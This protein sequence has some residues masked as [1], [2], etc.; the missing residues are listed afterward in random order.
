[1]SQPARTAALGLLTGLLGGC[2]VLLPDPEPEVVSPEWGYNGEET[3]VVIEGSGFWPQIEADAGSSGIG[4]VD[5]GFAVYLDDGSQHALSGVTL[6]DYGTLT[7]VVPEGLDAGVYDLVVEGP[8]GALGTLID[9]F[10]VT[11]TRADALTIDAEDLVYEVY[12]TAWLAVQLVDPEGQPLLEDLDVVVTVQTSNGENGAFEADSLLD[13]QAVDSTEG[14][15]IAG[16]LGDDGF[17]QIGVTMYEP[18][19]VDIVVEAFE[20]ESQVAEGV[21]PAQWEAGSSLTLSIALPDED[22]TAEAGETFEVVLT[23][24]DQYDNVVDDVTQ[25]VVLSNRCG[26][27]DASL[28][29][30][31]TE[32]LDVELTTATSDSCEADQLYAVDGPEGES[33]EFA[34]EAAVADTFSVTVDEGPSIAGEVDLDVFITPRDRFGNAADYTTTV[35]TLMDSVGGLDTTAGVGSATCVGSEL[36]YCAASGV[37]AAEDIVLTVSDPDGVSGTSNTY[38]IIAGDP[39]EVS[40]EVDS[41]PVTAGE[42]FVVTV[43]VLDAWGNVIDLD[44]LGAGSIALDDELSE[45]DCATGELDEDGGATFACTLYTAVSTNAFTASVASLSLEGTSD[46]FEVVNG[47]LA[48]AVI[49]VSDTTVTAGT[50]FEAKVYGYDAWGNLYLVQSDP[51]IDLEDTTGTWSVTSATL[52]A[53]ASATSLGTITVAGQTEL[54]ASQYGVELGSS[55]VITVE[56]GTISSLE[57]LVDEAWV[58]AG[59]AA[60]TYVT[61]VDAYGNTATSYAGDVE[62]NSVNGS[63][64]SITVALTAGEGAKAFVWDD[65]ALPDQLEGSTSGGKTG[66]SDDIYVVANCSTGPTARLTFSGYEEGVA[67]IAVSTGLATVSASLATSTAG[68]AALGWYGL[69]LSQTFDV[70][71]SDSFSVKIR[72]AGIYPA[73]ALVVDT[74]GCADEVDGWVYIGDDDGEPVGPLTVDLG[75]TGL[76]AG[77]STSTTS[78]TVS[79]VRDCTRDVSTGTVVL[80]TDLGDVTGA[81]S[82]GAGLELA[83]DSTGAASATLDLTTTIHDGTSNVWVGAA[84]GAALGQA[85]LLVDDESAHPFV[86]SQVPSGDTS[87][88]VSSIV[89]VLSEPL[90]SASV[91]TTAFTIETPDGTLLEPE[92]VAISSDAQTL[93][94]TLEDPVDADDGLFSVEATTSLRDRSGNRLD[95]TWSGASSTYTGWFGAVSVGAD[96]VDACEAD[97]STFRPDGDDGSGI[98]G[99]EVQ[100]TLESDTAPERWVVTVFDSDGDWVRH[101]RPSAAGATDTWL[102]DG[103]GSDGIIVPNGVY[104]IE[105]DADDGSGNRAGACTVEVT[106]D[107]LLE[108]LDE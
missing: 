2:G 84:S 10:T 42:S 63:G 54:M 101:E 40:V 28:F 105:I 88:S 19:R 8:T 97:V 83:L 39:A 30:Q 46:G 50:S 33:D 74:V 32:T 59:D 90:L 18:S 21:F 85:S 94:L 43:L 13:Q 44:T 76:S 23:V 106:V 62:V 72:E 79:D 102:W 9:G 57:V 56:P 67:C 55:T 51:R 77:V 96:P 47:D 22:F 104:S 29:V 27:F 80:R 75:D 103:R 41:D 16:R 12:D 53:S 81:S 100:L 26:G 36:I 49:V 64:D 14:F 45:A 98:E 86:Y 60:T 34:V 87:G 92:T 82:S 31:G 20:G 107:N 37:V 58:F 4:D 17:Q 25:S 5:R 38:T 1:M 48:E 11:S 15:A 70:D 73:T 95:G 108:E 89:L 35:L 99:D 68:S 52:G 65:V 66:T 24:L 93:T 61:A 7:A 71:T 69:E 3:S 6:E 78:I 91:T